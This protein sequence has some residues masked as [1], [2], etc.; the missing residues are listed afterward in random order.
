MWDCEYGNYKDMNN[1][2]YWYDD[3][4]PNGKLCEKAHKAYTD[5]ERDAL[6]TAA[7]VCGLDTSDWNGDDWEIFKDKVGI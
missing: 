4:Y 1:E 3:F 7:D 6:E 2:R 5:I